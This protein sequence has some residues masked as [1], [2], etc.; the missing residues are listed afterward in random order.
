MTID[1]QIRDKKLQ[2]DINR[3]D[4]K[5]SALLSKKVGKYKYLTGEEILPSNQKQVIEQAKVTYSPLGKAFLKQIKNNSRPRKK[6]VKALEDL[7]LK[8]QRK[9]IED[10]SDNNL[11][12]QK[13]NY[14]RLLGERVDEISK[15]SGEINYNKLIYYYNSGYFTT[16]ICFK[17]FKG[18]F[19]T[20]KEIRDGDKALQEIEQDQKNLKSSLGEITS[21][22]TKHKRE[23]PLDTIKNVQSLYDSRQKV[24]DLFNDNA[25]IRSEANYKSK[26]NEKTGTGLK[27]LTAKRMLQRLPIALAQIK[28]GNN[29]ESLLN[30]I[31]QIVYSLYQ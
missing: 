8:E 5:I 17:K 6:Q 7:R 23:Y 9:T 22:N 31:R 19:N 4:A 14:D 18:S 28:A 26:E 24:I 2:Y 29:S 13:E 21:G 11:S 30:E 25:D 10:K 27:I 3:E 20:F 12:I 15:I 1:D 16:P